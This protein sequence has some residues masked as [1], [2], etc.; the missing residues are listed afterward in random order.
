M[1]NS[2]TDLGLESRE[3]KRE[4][5]VSDVFKVSEHTSLEEHLG[6]TDTE[7]LLG[8]DALVDE[9]RHDGFSALLLVLAGFGFSGGQDGIALNFLPFS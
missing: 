7:V 6:E 5:L 3:D 1:M 8:E 9:L 4:L 2:P